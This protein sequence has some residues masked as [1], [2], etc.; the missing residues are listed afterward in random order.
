MKMHCVSILVRMTI[1]T[2]KSSGQNTPKYA[3][4]KTNTRETNNHSVGKR[5][6]LSTPHLVRFVYLV[7]SPTHDILMGSLM[8][9]SK[10]LFKSDSYAAV[11]GRIGRREKKK[12][13]DGKDCFSFSF[14]QNCSHIDE[15][16]TEQRGETV[17]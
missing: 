11:S 12:T 14:P 7:V 9:S 5:G 13:E 4:T 2:Q 3:L 16:R 8:G 6:T 17:V 10:Y 1:V 15:T